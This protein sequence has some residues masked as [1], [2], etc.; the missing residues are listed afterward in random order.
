MRHA[1]ALRNLAATLACAAAVPFAAAAEIQL[2]VSDLNFELVD[3]TPGDGVAPWVTGLT[4]GSPWP[5]YVDRAASYTGYPNEKNTPTHTVWEF[6]LGPNSALSWSFNYEFVT[7][8]YQGYGELEWVESFLGVASQA[9]ASG[10]NYGRDIF[11]L[12]ITN[13][14]ATQPQRLTFVEADTLGATVPGLPDMAVSGFVDIFI[15]GLDV[16]QGLAV[17]PMSPIP[18]PS[19]WAFMLAGAAA[20]IGRSRFFARK[21]QG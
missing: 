8:L 15:S 1:I 11:V 14:Q 13:D 16:Q 12:H 4:P 10:H 18:E 2:T 3:M 20:L 9:F 21:T 19:T 6:E 17:E 5:T 7:T